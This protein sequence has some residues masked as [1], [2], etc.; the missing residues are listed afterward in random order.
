MGELVEWRVFEVMLTVIGCV[1]F[2]LRKEKMV[3]KV[4]ADFMCL[5]VEGEQVDRHKLQGHSET[6]YLT[7][8]NIDDNCR[9]AAYRQI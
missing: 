1:G 3:S 6:S 2:S 8:Q 9:K 5:E 7:S 4:K